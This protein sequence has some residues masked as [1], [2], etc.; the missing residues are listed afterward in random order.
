[1]I[2]GAGLLGDLGHLYRDLI[3]VYI[4]G[5]YRKDRARPFSEVHRDRARG[6]KHKLDHREV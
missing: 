1:M 4:M 3:A 2:H 5:G 6:N